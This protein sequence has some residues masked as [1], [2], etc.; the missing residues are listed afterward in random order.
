M[1]FRIAYL[2]DRDSVGG[3]MEYIRV[4]SSSQANAECRVF[5]SSR[6]ECRARNLNAWRA[7]VIY[8]V[9]LRALLQVFGNPFFRPRAPVIFAVLGMHIR[10][11]DYLPKTFANRVRRFVRWCLENYLYRQCR[12]IVVQNKSDAAE[13]ARL[14]GKELKVSLD[15]PSLGT[16]SPPVVAPAGNPKWAYLYVARFEFQ[17][18]QDR[19]LE[20]VARHA[21]RFRAENGIT[22][23]VGSGSTRTSCQTFVRD[24][25]LEDLVQFEDE[26]TDIEPHMLQA[27]KIVSASRWEGH[28]YL[29]MKARALGCRVLATD[30]PGNRDVLAGYEKWEMLEL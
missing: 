15:V 24:H 14:Y 18:G 11:Y 2:I 13:I 28:P 7:D 3:G 21:D 16:W 9:H 19:W 8:A 6:G 12:E 25:G 10:K 26:T 4:K 29:L 23:F 27:G 5:F 17:K 1:S 30:C 20:H 22:L